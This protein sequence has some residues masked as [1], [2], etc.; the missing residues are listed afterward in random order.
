LLYCI[1]LAFPQCHTDIAVGQITVEDNAG[2]T[3]IIQ[4]GGTSMGGMSVSGSALT[5]KHSYRGYFA[6]TC[7]NAFEPTVFK[8]Y[9]FLDGSITFT[10]DLS[11]VG[12]ACNAAL[13]L[14]A[15][16]AYNS[17]QQPDP[18]KCGD[19]YCDA[20]DVCGLWCPEMDL[21]EAN[22]RAMQ[23]TPHKCDTPQGKFYPHCDG[24]GCGINTYKTNPNGYGYGTQYTIN[25][26]LPFVVSISFI[27]SNNVLSE[28]HTVISQNGKTFDF[29]HND[30]RCG[31]GY[32][33]S[34]TNAFKGGMLPTFSY[35][36]S[37][38]ATMSWLD[39]PPCTNNDNCNTGTTVTFSNIKVNGTVV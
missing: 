11:Q 37:T 33:A 24:G 16:P 6:K 34:M 14:V 20:N 9:N 23:V 2:P 17:N 38:A 13:Y 25:T 26:Q 4:T 10:A 1:S 39:I 29:S 21:F 5:V 32:L 8:S 22:N 27:T 36:G 19:Y 7:V 35:W 12:C 28:I 15:M 18:T 31:N 30:A 3:Y